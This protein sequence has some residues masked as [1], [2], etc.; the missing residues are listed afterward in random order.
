MIH[1]NEKRS[2]LLNLAA[3]PD[4]HIGALG[5]VDDT[6]SRFFCPGRVF[7]VF[8]IGAINTH[9]RRLTGDRGFVITHLVL[10]NRPWVE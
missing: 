4:K 1:Y 6:F 9:R 8:F 7:L 2:P 10:H 5:R 3:C